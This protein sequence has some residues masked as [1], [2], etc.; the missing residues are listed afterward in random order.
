[1]NESGDVYLIDSNS[2]LT[3][4]KSYY[5][6]DFAKHFWDSLH[7][8]INEGQIVILDV[9]REEIQKGDDELT[10]WINEIEDDLILSRNDAEIISSFRNVINYIKVE[11]CYSN[12]ALREWSIGSIADPW[13]IAA[14][15]A[16][17]YKIVTFEKTRGALN[18]NTPSKNAKIPE[19]AKV[20]GVECCDLFSMMRALKVAL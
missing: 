14:A 10:N 17:N 20:T 7:E 8:K 1:M 11:E 9:V 19:V 15:K 2:L 6:F 13:I 12:K 18:A 4:Y 16:Y 5:P 3:P